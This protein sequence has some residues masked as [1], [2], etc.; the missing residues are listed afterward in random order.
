[1][2]IRYKAIAQLLALIIIDLFAYYLSLTISLFIQMN[3]LYL[4]NF[5][6][7]FGQNIASYLFNL[8]YA[9]S[10]LWIPTAYIIILQF[11]KLYMARYPFWEESRIIFKAVTFTV[12][13]I[14]ITVTVRNL[15]GNISKMEFFVLWLALIFFLPFFRYWG[16]KLL[17]RIGLWR[18]N[19]LIIG[20][21]DRA[22]T[23]IKG[24]ENEEHLGYH[25][26]GVLDN[27]PANIGKT[28]RTKKRSYKVYGEIRNFDKFVSI[29][30]IE[31][32]FIA[33]P[34]TKPEE[35]TE[36]INQIYKVVKRVVIIPDIKGVSIFN[37]E[38]HYLFMEKLFMIKVNN[39][40]NSTPNRVVKRLFDLCLSII[41]LIL[42]SPLLVL[43]A[44]A[45]KATSQGPILFSQ[46]RIGKN[47]KEF[48]IFKF[49]T[50]YIDAQERL[51]HILA[52]DPKAKAE[53]EA[54]YKFKNDPRVTPVGKLLRQTSLDE[55]PQILNILKGN[56]ALVGPRPV[57]QDE[58]DKYYGTFRE[59]YFS[60]LP[61]LTGL[62][63]VSGRSDTDYDFRIQTD[64]WYVQNWSLWLDIII[65]IKSVPAVLKREGAY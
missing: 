7:I 53:W 46:S 2:R 40:L 41:G 22:L 56:M 48:K 32:I 64:V 33:S 62:W 58:I 44:I 12:V 57:I 1:M 17:F 39:S 30:K 26:I 47:G 14:Y 19:V 55:L 23:T 63:Q 34:Q 27:N 5:N 3:F 31:T 25:V 36:L 59:H 15:I 13:F 21:G 65:I 37:S 10:N 43:I 29:M 24:L 4:M 52:T 35:L 20:S 42:I 6:H 54:S 11:E 8:N 9:M 51:K 28:I 49:R 60:V 18:E 38:L 50:M 45:I 61:G 16:K